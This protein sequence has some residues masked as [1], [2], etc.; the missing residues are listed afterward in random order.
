MGEG[1]GMD[2]RREAMTVTVWRV[3]PVSDLNRVIPA[4][5]IDANLRPGYISPS[6]TSSPRSQHLSQ[7][8]QACGHNKLLTCLICYPKK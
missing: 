4:S 2:R 5:R 8:Q 6:F 3:R 1:E 7:S